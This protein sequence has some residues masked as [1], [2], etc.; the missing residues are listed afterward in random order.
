MASL[1]RTCVVPRDLE[2]AIITKHV[3]RVAMEDDLVVPEF[4]NLLLQSPTTS[5]LREPALAN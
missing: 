4:V 5:R 1:G 2:P 3:Y